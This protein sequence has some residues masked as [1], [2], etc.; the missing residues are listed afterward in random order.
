MSIKSF[1]TLGSSSAGY[2]SM[3]IQRKILRICGKNQNIM[4]RSIILTSTIKLTFP[5]SMTMILSLCRTVLSRCAIVM[6]VQSE[7]QSLS[8]S[9]IIESVTVSMLAVASSSTKIY[10]IFR[11]KAESSNFTFSKQSLKRLSL[12]LRTF[13]EKKK[14]VSI[15]IICKSRISYVFTL[16]LFAI[17]ENCMEK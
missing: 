17:A 10:K 5:A 11:N 15:E 4:W 14:T 6:I 7:K 16:I 8:V 3:G 2:T 12:Q 1:I 9:C 13:F